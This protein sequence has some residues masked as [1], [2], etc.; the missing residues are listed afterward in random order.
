MSRQ[1]STPVVVQYG[2]YECLL[3]HEGPLGIIECP[4]CGGLTGTMPAGEQPTLEAR[5]AV[6]WEERAS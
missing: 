2:C 1:R 6:A 4:H 3:P 5:R